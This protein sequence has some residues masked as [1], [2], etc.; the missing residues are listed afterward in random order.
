M[1]L[2]AH[3]FI[4]QRVD[5]KSM[6][7]R[8]YNKFSRTLCEMCDSLTPT[9]VWIFLYY[10]RT[11]QCTGPSPCVTLILC[12]YEVNDLGFIGLIFVLILK[13][14]GQSIGLLIQA[15]NTS[16]I[17][18]CSAMD[19]SSPTLYTGNWLFYL[20]SYSRI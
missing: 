13:C 18:T 8:Q 9:D 5:V 4:I 2:A 17:F 3:I 11:A 20:P 15:P 16:Q 10:C 12:F 1:K 14:M 6:T 7:D 19:E